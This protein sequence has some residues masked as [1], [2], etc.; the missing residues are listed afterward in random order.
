MKYISYGKRVGIR[1]EDEGSAGMTIE[2]YG[3]MLL[4]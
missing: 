1:G 3:T 4:L 2:F